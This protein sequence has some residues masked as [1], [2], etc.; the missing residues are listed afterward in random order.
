MKTQASTTTTEQEQRKTHRSS[1]PVSL[2]EKSGAMLDDARPAAATQQRI[3]RIAETSPR[4]ALPQTMQAMM[5]ASPQTRQLMSSKAMIS[6]G[7]KAGAVQLRSFNPYAAA[8]GSTGHHIIPHSV[9]IKNMERIPLGEQ[10]AV[11][12]KFLP[13]LDNLTLAN[14]ISAAIE[15]NEVPFVIKYNNVIINKHKLTNNQPAGIQAVAATPLASLN[16]VERGRLTFDDATFDTFTARYTAIKGNTAADLTAKEKG[17]LSAFYEWQAGNQFAGPSQR[18][19]P[20][21]SDEFD[22]DA[23]FALN[24]EAYTAELNKIYKVLKPNADAQTLTPEALKLQLARLADL[25][26][27]K[28]AP[29][30][31]DTRWVELNS[32]ARQG[33]LTAIEGY[34]RVVASGAIGA[35]NNNKKV[36]KDLITSVDSG[37][38]KTKIRDNMAAY[39]E[40]GWRWALDDLNNNRIPPAIA[41]PLYPDWSVVVAEP[42]KLKLRELPGIAAVPVEINHKKYQEPELV[43]ALCTLFIAGLRKTFSL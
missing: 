3:Q 36:H 4:A 42:N 17:M 9:L 8:D 23:Q 35:R 29:D 41:H 16:G 5:A 30:V 39:N 21:T 13:A 24:D 40:R 7:A 34:D 26:R 31:D 18:Y 37:K 2:M 19:E 32:D 43:S 20:G 27:G 38:L 22:S 14:L 6:Q 1:Q 11:M 25:T 10:P 15:V 28:N 12:C 33:L